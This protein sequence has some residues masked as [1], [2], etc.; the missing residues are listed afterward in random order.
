V[1][2]SISLVNIA[3]LD[4]LIEP[5]N[6]GMLPPGSASRLS[7]VIMMKYWTPRSTAQGIS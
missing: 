4:P 7:E 1:D 6:C 5:A 3:L 2:D